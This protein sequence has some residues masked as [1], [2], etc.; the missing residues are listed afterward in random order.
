MVEVVP[1]LDRPAGAPHPRSR[2]RDGRADPTRRRA[3]L[4][5]GSGRCRRRSPCFQRDLRGHLGPA[6][7]PYPPRPPQ[8]AFGGDRVKILVVSGIWPPDV[9]GPASHAPEVAAFLLGR[10]HEVE[11]VTTADSDPE[12]RDYPV[13]WVDRATPIGVRHARTAALIR[14]RAAHSDV[15]YTTGMFGR[16]AAGARVASRPYIVKLTADPAFERSRRRG[17][18][19]GS[20]EAFQQG[21][22]G[23][24]SAV[25]RAARNSEL[26]HATHVLCPS[27]YLRQIALGWGLRADHVSVLPNPIPALPELPDRDVLRRQLR[28]NGATLAFAGRL[29]R[30]KSLEVALD[31]LVLADGVTLVVAGDG[32]ERE[33]LE[34]RARE[35][36]LGDRARFLGALPREQVLELFRAADALVLSSTWENFP[37]TVVE[38]LAVGTPVLATSAGGVAEVV[39]DE[40]NGLLFEPGDAE[41]L[42]RAMQ[43]FFADDELRARLGEQAA[44]SVS[45][46]RPEHVYARLEKI[47]EGA[48]R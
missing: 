23:H 6:R 42:A 11:V 22:G 43:R 5:L 30:Q 3:R 9:G 2:R 19:S 16:S 28:L 17:F 1:G 4:P 15:L 31:A 45:G 46:Y 38:A 20:L 35:L 18:F 36:S 34:R 29:T 10:G 14:K 25:L 13:R 41:A 24:R 32:D 7:P 37:H 26:R 8:G 40:Q 48:A 33:S 12:P 44:A 21:G 47:L 39:E 27:E